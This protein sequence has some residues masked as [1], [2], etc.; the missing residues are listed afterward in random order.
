MLGSACAPHVPSPQLLCRP[1]L[2]GGVE[3]SPAVSALLSL[4]VQPTG[5]GFREPI[6]WRLQPQAGLE[7]GG[8]LCAPDASEPPSTEELHCSHLGLSPSFCSSDLQLQPQSRKHTT[9]HPWAQ[10]R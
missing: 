2:Q 3:S 10:I 8:P 1:M 4:D 6:T 5:T 7:T 9:L